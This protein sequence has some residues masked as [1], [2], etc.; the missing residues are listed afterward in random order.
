MNTNMKKYIGIIGA[1]LTALALVGGG[2]GQQAPATSAPA[3]APVAAPQQEAPTP[4]PA[5]TAEAKFKVNDRVE[6]R[7]NNGTLWYKGTIAAHASGQY[8]INYD[9]GDKESGIPETRIRALADAAVKELFVVGDTV[10]A[11]LKSGDKWYSG[12]ISAAADGSFSVVYDDGNKETGITAAR[13]AHVPTVAVVVKSGDR[14][15]AKWKDGKWYTATVTS[16]AGTKITVKYY[17]G[18]SLDIT[19]NDIAIPAK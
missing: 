7:W 16:V 14:V 2:C 13:I 3:P 5:P 9:D 11:N 4:A 19:G 8:S 10:I 12:K 15:V 1:S 6:S 18:Y 17:D